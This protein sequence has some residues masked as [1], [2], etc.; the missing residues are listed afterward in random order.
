VSASPPGTRPKAAP[1]DSGG[2]NR[3]QLLD[4]YYYMRLTRALEERIVSLYRQGRVPGGVYRSLGQEA[5]AVA[6]AYALEPGDICS[7]V[8]RNL[9]SMLVMG[10]RP[11]EVLRQYQA[12]ATSPTGG[13]DLHVMFSDLSRGYL[14]HVAPLGVMLP[15]IAGVALAF[16]MSGSRRVVL[17]YSGDGATSTG[18]FHE[19]L[20]FAAVQQL[21]LVVVVENNGFAYSTPTITETVVERL[22]DK[23]EGYGVPGVRVDGNDPLAVYGATRAAVDRARA[24]GGVTLIEAV[25]YRRAGHA[26]HDDQRY[27][28]RSEIAEWAARDPLERYAKRLMSAGWAGEQEISDIDARITAE[29]DRAVDACDHDALP[30]PRSGIADVY[31]RT[32]GAEPLWF[33]RL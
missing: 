9:G 26:E 21:P 2:L 17:A 12:K 29:L 20:N 23:A 14:G 7:P 6:S 33:R 3:D 19:G 25:T 24:G 10:A 8:I 28:S 1:V 16:R 31:A 5:E 27:Q 15:V 4:I 30:E 11:L 22:A 18:A 32:S 13:R